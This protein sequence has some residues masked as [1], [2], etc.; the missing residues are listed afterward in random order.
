MKEKENDP[1][2]RKA[3]VV[4]VLVPFGLVRPGCGVV[5][6]LPARF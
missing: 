6:A 5:P 2:S 4:L 1:G 3:I